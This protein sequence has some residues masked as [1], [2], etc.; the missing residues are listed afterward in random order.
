M[1]NWQKGGLALVA[2]IASAYITVT[3][4]ISE[5]DIPF[6]AQSLVIFVV[7]ALLSP[8]VFLA[9]ICSY[10]FL[11][12]LGLPVFAEGS[13]GWSKLIGPSGGFLI[14]FLFSGLFISYRLQ[15]KSTFLIQVL[16]TMII[17]TGILF[18]FG[19]GVLTSK[20]GFTKALE[21]G[22][23]PFWI[24]ALVKAVMSAILVYLLKATRFNSGIKA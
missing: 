21:Y 3:L 11:G 8:R 6:T 7:A 16:L 10:L 5:K 12:G 18:L 22:F 14:G 9:T 13:A 17:A 1:G 23:Y 24:M 19:L 20:F 4:P 2:I 15:D